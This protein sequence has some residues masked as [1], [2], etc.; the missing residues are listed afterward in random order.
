MV[1]PQVHAAGDDSIAVAH[2]GREAGRGFGLLGFPGED[3]ARGV[4]VKVARGR[5]RPL[6]GRTC[7]ALCLG[8]ADRLGGCPGRLGQASI[9][10]EDPEIGGFVELAM[11]LC[12]LG[13]PEQQRAERP[14]RNGAM[15]GPRLRCPSNRGRRGRPVRTASPGFGDDCGRLRGS[16]GLF[17]TDTSAA[18]AGAGVAARDFPKRRDKRRGSGSELFWLSSAGLPRTTTLSDLFC[19]RTPATADFGNLVVQVLAVP[20]I[21][22]YSLDLD[23]FGLDFVPLACR[24]W[25]GVDPAHDVHHSAIRPVGLAMGGQPVLSGKRRIATT[26][27][28]VSTGCEQPIAVRN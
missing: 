17:A 22:R 2:H 25:P 1:G 14:G 11:E 23:D 12:Y 8:R 16:S 6:Q 28:F 13:H 27:V 3:F 9:L 26:R 5:P 15:I 20:V 24:F 21:G 7:P 19:V 4:E 18:C 10:V